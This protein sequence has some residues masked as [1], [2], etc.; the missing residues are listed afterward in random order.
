MCIMTRW[1]SKTTACNVSDTSNHNTITTT[2]ASIVTSSGRTTPPL[3]Q[4]I[5]SSNWLHN[6]S[7]PI[8][9]PNM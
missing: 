6:H 3:L 1:T 4:V 2:I 7:S 8:I 5:L 9:S